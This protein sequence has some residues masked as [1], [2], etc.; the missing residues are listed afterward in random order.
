MICW[1]NCCLPPQWPEQKG[2]AY[3]LAWYAFCCHGLQASR[4]FYAM[5]RAPDGQKR[6]ICLASDGLQ[7]P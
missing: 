5:N 6:L 4:Q 2:L 7:G 3:V 1:L